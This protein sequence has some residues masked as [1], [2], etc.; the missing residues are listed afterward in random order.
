MNQIGA[1]L[2]PISLLISLLAAPPLRLGRAI[3]DFGPVQAIAAQ[4]TP[5]QLEAEY[6]REQNPKKRLSIGVELMNER[7]KELLDAF[8]SQDPEKQSEAVNT[9]LNAADRVEKAMNEN[10]NLGA[11]KNAEIRLRRQSKTLSDLRMT[12]SAAD[13]IP[14]DKAVTRLDRI[15]EIL[16]NSIMHPRK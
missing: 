15:H 1:V 8:D 9:Y 10:T 6:D 12:L 2:A 14:L 4:K 13:Q 7:L 16:L 3:F 11:V 5:A